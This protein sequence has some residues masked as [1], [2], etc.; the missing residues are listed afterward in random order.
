MK[1]V[2]SGEIPPI[3]CV[4]GTC[5]GG[6]GKQVYFID[7]CRHIHQGMLRYWILSRQAHGAGLLWEHAQ[8]PLFGTAG[9]SPM[10]HMQLEETY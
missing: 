7:N 8:A 2:N 9:A 5:K 4:V 6:G 10:S 1:V 3:V